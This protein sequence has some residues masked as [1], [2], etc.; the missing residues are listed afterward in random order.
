VNVLGSKAALNGNFDPVPVY[1][2]EEFMKLSEKVPEADLEQRCARS[3]LAVACGG[4]AARPLVGEVP[5]ALM[6][7][8]ELV[9]THG[10]L[11]NS[12]ELVGTNGNFRN[13]SRTYRN[14]WELMGT[15]CARLSGSYLPGGSA[16]RLCPPSRNHRSHAGCGI[17]FAHSS[18][19]RPLAGLGFSAGWG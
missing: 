12:R 13:L 18:F 9:G 19:R 4:S 16:V 10:N 8:P 3:G 1:S 14:L 7:V 11:W 2:W 6:H 5:K 15:F 17:E